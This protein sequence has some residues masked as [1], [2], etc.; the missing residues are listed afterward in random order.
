MVL[1]NQRGLHP[2]AEVF[3]VR[4][5]NENRRLFHAE[6]VRS[7]DEERQPLS[8]HCARIKDILVRSLLHSSP[9]EGLDCCGGLDSGNCVAE[10]P[11]A[12]VAPVFGLNFDGSNP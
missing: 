9:P 8:E 12:Q 3:P 7:I 4:G 1:Q 10:L 2:S 6:I 5:L 11:S